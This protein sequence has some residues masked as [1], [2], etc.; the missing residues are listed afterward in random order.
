MRYKVIKAAIIKMV[1]FWDVAP[2]FTIYTNLLGKKYVLQYTD[3]FRMR[4]FETFLAS[5]SLII[6]CQ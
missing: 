6:Y 4:S 2:C 1:V 5:L 3:I